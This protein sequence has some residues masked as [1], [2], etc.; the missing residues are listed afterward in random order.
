MQIMFV[1]TMQ[2][3]DGVLMS[4]VIGILDHRG[5]HTKFVRYTLLLI[6]NH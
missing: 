1:Y 6:L 5:V 2:N 3:L 4:A